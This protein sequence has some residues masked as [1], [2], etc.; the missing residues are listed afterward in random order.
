METCPGQYDASPTPRVARPRVHARRSS[1]GESKLSQ[2]RSRALFVRRF[3]AAF[4]LV[5]FALAQVSIF[6]V[7]RIPDG[8]AK[9]VGT[10]LLGEVYA[11]GGLVTY[12]AILGTANLG[13]SC[14]LLI[15]AIIG[16]GALYQSAELARIKPSRARLVF[17]AVLTMIGSLAWHWIGVA[18]LSHQLSE[19]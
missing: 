15:A 17:L 11:V 12:I 13:V 5:G 2:S 14:T 4:W 6:N 7:A 16:Y 18:T 8:F 10:F 19:W 9:C 1:E 3:A